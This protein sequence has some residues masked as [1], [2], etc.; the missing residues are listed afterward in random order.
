MTKETKLNSN[1]RVALAAIL[2]RTNLGKDPPSHEEVQ[3]L[4]EVKNLTIENAVSNVFHDL[5]KSDEHFETFVEEG[6]SFLGQIIKKSHDILEKENPKE[7]SLLFSKISSEA[8]SGS[9]TPKK[10]ETKMD[11]KTESS[12]K[13]V[14][15][16]RSELGLG[17]KKKRKLSTVYPEGNS[18][19]ERI[20]SITK[21]LKEHAQANLDKGENWDTILKLNDDEIAHLIGTGR[22]I[23]SAIAGIKVKLQT[24]DVKTIQTET[25][26]KLAERQNV[27]ALTPEQKEPAPKGEGDKNRPEFLN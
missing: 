21:G 12:S 9:V 27:Q 11:S 20:N 1:E 2:A 5:I 26:A 17:E 3:K 18:R 25:A 15:E 23:G 10:E 6:K 14:E 13:D 7:Y 16:L 22:T 19:Q 4:L 8:V 24:M